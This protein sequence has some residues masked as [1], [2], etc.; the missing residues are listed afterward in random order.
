M[1]NK[2]LRMSARYMVLVLLASLTACGESPAMSNVPAQKWQKWIVQVEPRPSPAVTGMNEILVVITDARG[3][4][5]NGFIV[6]LRS[7]NQNQW[8]QAMEDGG[9]GVYRR[10]VDLGFGKSSVVEVQLER[11]GKR[12]ILRYPL[13][14]KKA[15]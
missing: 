6:S 8:V 2:L 5:G 14:L 13:E 7:S 11:D 1:T 10:A 3:N 15:S 12:G 9:L 4:P